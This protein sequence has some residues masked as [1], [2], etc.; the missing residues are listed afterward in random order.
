MAVDWERLM[1]L[2]MNWRRISPVGSGYPFSK[3]RKVDLEHGV[4]DGGGEVSTEVAESLGEGGS[5]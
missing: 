2:I 4:S 1:P 5:G 3:G